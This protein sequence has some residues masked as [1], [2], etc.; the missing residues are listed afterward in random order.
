MIKW[1]DQYL[2]DLLRVVKGKMKDRDP[3]LSP[4]DKG[5]VERCLGTPRDS[6]LNETRPK[7]IWNM[8][9]ANPFSENPLPL[10][11]FVV[12]LDILFLF[13]Y[14]QHILKTGVDHPIGI[15]AP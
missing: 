8:E 14:I 10:C 15:L 12:F 2:H 5:R 3:V 7:G 11:P 4:Q 1:F 9:E 6:L 13:F